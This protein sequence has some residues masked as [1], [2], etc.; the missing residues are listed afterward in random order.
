M[1]GVPDH[2]TDERDT[3]SFR[4]F[5]ALPGVELY[6]AH[7]SRYAFE[8]H[9]H[10]AFGIGTIEAGA[11]RFRYRGTHYV[12]AVNSL[13]TMNPDELHTG[14]AETPD[15]WRYRMI[16][17]E[18]AQLAE[19]TGI[20]QWWF[21]DVER[22]DALRAAQ[23]GRLIGALWSAE[24][25]LAQQSLLLDLIDTIRPYA[26]HGRLPGSMNAPRFDQVRHYLHDN[27]MH[28][29]TLGELAQ[30]AALS[31]YHFLRQ[32]KAQY[33]VTPHQMLMAIRLWRAK[34]FLAQGMPAAEVASATGLTDQSHLTRT[35]SQRYGLTPVR[36]QRQVLAR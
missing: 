14:E 19:I 20:D 30:V 6:H 28:P 33:H 35:F 36:Y 17:L 29:V 7:I 3:A 25:P 1:Q 32:F 26:S 5:S 13:V 15:G 31:P 16:Y 22:C 34:L 8:P 9:T 11:E 12:A 24:T 21:N 23:T 18:P 4:Q 2:F 10:E 27:Y